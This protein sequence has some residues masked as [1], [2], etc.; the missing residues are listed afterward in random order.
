M[1]I[2]NQSKIKKMENQEKS[3]GLKTAVAVLAFGLI[4]SV[5][6]NIKQSQDVDVK[7][8][9]FATVTA[10]KNEVLTNLTSLK[11]KYDT[12]IAEN[13]SMADEL[14]V[15]RDK[16]VKLL[17]EVRRAK[18]SGKS[19]DGYKQRYL[20][21]NSKM[22]SLIAENEG[23]TKMN[24]SL[25]VQRDS[26]NS[27]LNNTKIEKET[28]AVQNTEMTKTIEVA[29]KLTVSNLKASAFKIRNS[30]KQV[31]TDKARRADA[32]KIDFTI[33]ENKIAKAGDKDYY[34]QVIDANNNVIG[35]KKTVNFEDKELN[36]SFVSNVKYDNK[37]V[38]VSELLP[39][40]DFAKGN[41]FV[42]VF[43]KNEL[44]SNSSFVL[45]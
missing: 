1:I 35:E 13:T 23:L 45:R 42:N 7:Q 12:A 11:L 20:E 8:I 15:E 25:I 4:G 36:Y 21:L 2:I 28:L 41:Y 27:V 22:N 38:N 44:V 5:G 30:G 29:S 32:L 3:S 10:E 34:V 17:D 16:V 6:Y 9:A 19:I 24:S 31:E 43:D 39:G 37:S 18:N 14:I 26:T 40:K 33:A